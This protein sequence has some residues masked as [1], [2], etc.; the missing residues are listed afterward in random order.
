MDHQDHLDLLRPGVTIPGG[1]WADLG[2]GTRAFT[3]AL[4][5]LVGLQ[6]VIYSVDKNRAALDEQSRLMQARLPGVACHYLV[7]DFTKP[8]DLPKLDGIVMA[9]ALHFVVPLQKLEVVRQLKSYL[10]PEAGLILVEYN[11]DRG[12]PWVPYPL[13]CSVWTAL[14]RQAGFAHSRSL[15]RKPSRFLKEFYSVLSW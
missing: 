1:T 5:E 3:L 2:S 14:A 7:A 10:K 8:L 9:N 13:S 6:A 12:N 4:A 11:V 15:G